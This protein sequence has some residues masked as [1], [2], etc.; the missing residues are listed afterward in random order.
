MLFFTV[1]FPQFI[2]AHRPVLPQFALLTLEFMAIS[3][4]S[5]LC[6]ATLASRT[7]GALLK[8]LFAV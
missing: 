5:H 4:P 1:L 2:D 7:R 8:P 3:Y 6:Y